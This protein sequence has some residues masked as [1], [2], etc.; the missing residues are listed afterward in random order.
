MTN[1]KECRE[2]FEKCYAY[3][4]QFKEKD[5]KHKE[6]CWA[7]WK[8]ANHPT[9]NT[10]PSKPAL[11][12]DEIKRILLNAASGY[13]IYG[14]QLNDT[15]ATMLARALAPYLQPAGEWRDIETAPEDGTMFLVCLPRMGNLIVRAR[16]NT[17]HGYFVDEV[18]NND[19]VSRP[20]F[21]HKGD[22]WMPLPT[23]PAT[24]TD[25]E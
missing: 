22:Y 1:D 24:N 17:V 10:R 12:E 6:D 23:P 13:T 25:G 7:I 18:D 3:K 14:S 21:Y 11:S 16:Y 20:A 15:M 2:A 4:F 5:A 19:S 9:W 8:S